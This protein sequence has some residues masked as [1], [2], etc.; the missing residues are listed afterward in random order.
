MKWWIVRMS[1]SR[2]DKAF[3]SYEAAI[4]Y[5]KSSPFALDIPPIPVRAQKRSGG[6]STST[7]INRP[8]G[9]K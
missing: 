7:R 3:S 9:Q 4:S 1:L 5:Q 8:I 2:C 6:S